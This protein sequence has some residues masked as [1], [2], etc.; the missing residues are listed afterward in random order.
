MIVYLIIHTYYLSIL[1]SPSPTNMGDTSF[2]GKFAIG[3]YIWAKVKGYPFW[4]AR[5]VDDSQLPPS[6]RKIKNAH[7]VYFY[8]SNN[9]ACVTED[10][11]R[12]YEEAHSSCVTA[13]KTAPFKKAVKLIESE[14]LDKT[15]KSLSAVASKSSGLSTPKT[16]N[17]SNASIS[18]TPESS[19]KKSETA[20]VFK[21]TVSVKKSSTTPATP[22]QRD[23]SRTP[24]KKEK[25]NFESTLD[26][27]ISSTPDVKKSPEKK[28]VKIVTPPPSAKNVI[29]KFDNSEDLDNDYID[30]PPSPPPH[31]SPPSST[32][33]MESVVITKN[34]NT[35]K[36]SLRY[37]FIGLGNLGQQLLKYLLEDKREVTIWNRTLSKCDDFESLGAVVAKTP[38][39]VVRESDIIFSCLADGA[40]A[41]KIFFG[42]CGVS[43]EIGVTKGYVELS[44]LDALTSKNISTSIS[45]K[46]GRYL[47]APF[48][49]PISKKLKQRSMVVLASG[50]RSLFDDC[51]PFFNVI[52]KRIFFLGE[53]AG[54]ASRMNN[55]VSSLCS[56]IVGSLIESL[57][58]V[59]RLGFVA[60]D[61]M[62]IVNSSSIAS[63]MIEEN[64]EAMASGSYTRELPIGHIR[65]D[66]SYALELS[67]SLNCPTPI[68]ATANEMFKQKKH[69]SSTHF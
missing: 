45:S 66:L 46:G 65:R 9:Y 16:P 49:I 50:D 14:I 5:I 40:A 59:D 11:I 57:A 67:N 33:K 15:G 63:S 37:G 2:S 26:S 22:L 31:L 3:D 41:A 62:E 60:K 38:G 44:S 39:D 20:S 24:F 8:G 43:Q 17:I 4:P 21:P 61:F 18:F 52:C 12:N 36:S 29:S 68:T 47:E 53:Q 30:N 35:P 54:Q 32:F 27:S 28:R 19:P 34:G 10:L 48:I 7:C 23:Y 13:N 64:A 55:I 56:N 6:A 51:A 69:Y 58:L 25:R 1:Y 42:N